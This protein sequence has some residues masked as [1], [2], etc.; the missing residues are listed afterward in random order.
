[1]NA[2]DRKGDVNLF[3]LIVCFLFINITLTHGLQQRIIQGP[4]NLQAKI[5]DQVTLKCQIDNLA[6]EPQWCID[7]FCLGLSRKT[8]SKSTG[9]EPITLKGRPRHKIVGDPSKGE[10][11]LLI[12]PVQLQDNMHFFCMAT[13]ALVG[14]KEVKAVKSD[15]IFLTVL[16]KINPL[17]LPSISNS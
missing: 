11:H 15:Q 3:S 2:I 1:M 6:G 4:Q 8:T 12:E 13:A 14:T 5:G 9:D 7:D 17:K 16:S 10:Y